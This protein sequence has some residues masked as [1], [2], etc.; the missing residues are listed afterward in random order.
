[1]ADS[2]G[3]NAFTGQKLSDWAHV[4]QSI[5]IIL[6]TPIG[7]RVMRRDFGSNLPDL[8]DRK[9]TPRGVLAVYSAAA[10]AIDKYEPR[11][12]LTKASITAV[13]HTG[14]IG[15]SLFGTYYP[16]GHL[17]DYSI[18]EDKTTRIV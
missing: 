10:L 4:E 18:A 3:V 15:L 12:Q 13:N 2:T 6:T 17:G 7:S 16:R 5:N 14:H 8:V 1:M 9:L 11:F